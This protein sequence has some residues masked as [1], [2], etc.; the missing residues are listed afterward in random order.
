M[1]GGHSFEPIYWPFVGGHVG[2]GFLTFTQTLVSCN[3]SSSPKHLQREVLCDYPVVKGV[4]Y[5]VFEGVCAGMAVLNPEYQDAHNQEN[6]SYIGA[7]CGFG[8]TY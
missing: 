6:Q 1:Q 8:L 4:G 7:S 3:S 5:Q 2:T